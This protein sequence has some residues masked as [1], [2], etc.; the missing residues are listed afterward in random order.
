MTLAQEEAAAME[1]R[2]ARESAGNSRLPDPERVH[3]R[4]LRSP[5]RDREDAA[6]EAEPAPALEPVTEEGANRKV[7][8]EAEEEEEGEE[9]E[10]EE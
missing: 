2:K 3:R 6:A 4:A 7:P 5:S 10:P 9:G 1:A 8:S